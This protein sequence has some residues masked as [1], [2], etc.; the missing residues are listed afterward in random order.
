MLLRRPGG[1]TLAR[2]SFVAA[3]ILTVSPKTCFVLSSGC[4]LCADRAVAK[5]YTPGG[6]SANVWTKW[7]AKVAL[8]EDVV[9]LSY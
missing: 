2:I 5:T 4:R 1:H 6:G 3:G 8:F 9:V 7:S